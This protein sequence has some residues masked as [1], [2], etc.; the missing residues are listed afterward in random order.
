LEDPYKALGVSREASQEEIRSAYLRLAK[1]HHPDLNPGNAKAEERFKVVSAANELLSDPERRGQFD[2]G[3]IDAA[4][5]ERAA[6][7]SY[8]DYAEGE[9]GRRYGPAGPQSPGWSPEDLEAMF[10]S[11]FGEDFRPGGQT[12]RRGGD[13]RYS[14][15][16]EF[17]EAINGAT[18]RLTL[19][20]GRTLDVKIPPGMADGEVLRLR[21][22]GGKGSNGGADGDALIEIHIAPHRFF[23]RDGQDIRLELPVS[24]SEA[25]LGGSI[26]VPTPG[27]IVRMR[28]PPHSDSG[29]ELRL[30]GRGVPAHGGLAKGDMYATLQVVLGTPDAALEDF[31]RNWKPE[32]LVD[33]RRTM[34]GSQ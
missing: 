1:Q 24:L 16:T 33:P 8:R 15:T 32:H 7:P 5:H 9:P 3:E 2:R 13:E 4:G 28:V 26:D 10:G 20:E 25:V 18:R 6:R 12:Q 34:E 29:T 22:Q 31:L 14:L 11:M 27:G 19:P 21:G 30:R 23:R 17:L